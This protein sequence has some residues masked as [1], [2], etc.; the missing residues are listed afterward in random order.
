M[1]GT[2]RDARV[3]DVGSGPLSAAAAHDPTDCTSRS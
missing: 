2:T 1:T 3:P